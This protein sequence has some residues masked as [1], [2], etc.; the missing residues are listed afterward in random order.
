MPAIAWPVSFGRE[1]LMPQKC[2]KTKPFFVF[3]FGQNELSMDIWKLQV[4]RQWP[5]VSDFVTRFCTLRES[6]NTRPCKNRTRNT[7]A[8]FGHCLQVI[9]VTKISVRMTS[10]LALYVQESS[11]EER[12]S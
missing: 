8:F 2:L 7:H 4:I 9:E 10:F 11:S 3:F 6:E 5:E 12:S 1:I